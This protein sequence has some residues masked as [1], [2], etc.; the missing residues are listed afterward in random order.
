[1]FGRSWKVFAVSLVLVFA[2]GLTAYAQVRSQ[3]RQTAKEKPDI[4]AQQRG[5]GQRP[6]APGERPEP[7]GRQG[8]QGLGPGNAQDG[9][10]GL[11]SLQRILLP[12]NRRELQQLSVILGLTEEQKQQIKNLYQQFINTVRPICQQRGPA[13]RN[14]LSVLGQPSP[15]R[16]AL[17]SAANQVLQ[18]DKAILDAEFDFWVAFKNVLNVQQQQALGQALQQRALREEVGGRQGPT[19]P[20]APGQ[21]GPGGRT[22]GRGGRIG[23]GAPPAPA[24]MP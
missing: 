22:G 7:T 8:A 17:Q 4:A 21:A 16:G 15:S 10:Q 23:P 1:M 24:P 3:E 5:P 13:I 19:G 12:P 9:L 11:A 18:A 6:G 2:L 14:V 20:M